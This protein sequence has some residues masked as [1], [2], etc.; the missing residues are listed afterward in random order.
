M[1]WF[2]AHSGARFIFD[3][4]CNRTRMWGLHQRA[5]TRGRDWTMP[6]ISQWTRAI[7]LTPEHS[8]AGQSGISPALALVFAQRDWFPIQQH[9]PCLAMAELCLRER[10]QTARAG[11]GLQPMEHLALVI[12]EPAHW[13]FLEDL[14]LAVHRCFKHA[15]IWVVDGEQ[16]RSLDDPIETAS[17]SEPSTN[18]PGA[19]IA[20]PTP[21]PPQPAP[22]SCPP[23]ED[24]TLS[25]SHRISRAEIDMLLDMEA[26]DSE[27]PPSQIQPRA[28]R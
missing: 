28:S 7:V 11:W 3:R 10:A 8:E 5:Q 26:A 15:S 16:L 9:D 20:E 22:A 17:I 6:E 25:Q 1:R 19:S 24:S 21:P 2:Q 4:R 27:A 23:N 13:P 18:D 12:V 14:V